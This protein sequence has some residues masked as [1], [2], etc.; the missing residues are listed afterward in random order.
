MPPSRRTSVGSV[1]RN[2]TPTSGKSAT[3]LK[4]EGADLQS[5]RLAKGSTSSNGANS[6]LKRPSSGGPKCEKKKPGGG[7]KDDFLSLMKE[8][9]KISQQSTPAVVTAEPA[10]R[11]VSSEGDHSVASNPSSLARRKD[12]EVRPL[13]KPIATHKPSS[14]SALSAKSSIDRKSADSSVTR[15]KS[16]NPRAQFGELEDSIPVKKSTKKSLDPRTQFA[17]VA[18]GELSSRVTASRPSSGLDPRT[19]FALAAGGELPSR[20]TA[21]RPFS[22]RPNPPAKPV[23]PSDRKIS[24]GDT[25]RSNSKPTSAVSAAGQKDAAEQRERAMKR[26]REL[27]RE[28]EESERRGQKRRR[29]SDEDERP[30]N[31]S[32]G[33]RRD[34]DPFWREE[35]DI[36]DIG[37]MIWKLMG[38]DKSK[39]VGRDDFDDSDME[40]DSRSIRLEESRSARLARLED[41]KEAAALEKAER[42]RREAK[43]QAK[44]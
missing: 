28:R 41:E 35:D 17:L 34:V 1:A 25:A 7:N 16:M 33:T 29:D 38:K 5:R 11:R 27:E 21:P 22:G 10:K 6:A 39:Y 14:S 3:L 43:R 31:T 13:S 19:Q 37:S 26:K 44:R 12:T 32:R 18:G 15:A 24:P 8:A 4:S 20:N 30:R 2:T 40:A 36:Q 42:L 23:K 9:E